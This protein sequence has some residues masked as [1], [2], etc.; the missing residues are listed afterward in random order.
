M[1]R[2]EAVCG[3]ALLVWAALASLAC[4]SE[5]PRVLDAPAG[6]L[7]A[8]AAVLE[9]LPYAIG[10][11][12]VLRVNVFAHPELSSGEWKQ[13][14]AGSPVDGSGAVMLPLL[15]AVPVAGATVAEVAEVL[16]QR[17]LRYLKE[18][19]VDVAVLEFG[20][21]RYVVYGAV[22]TPGVYALERPTTLLEALA[23][24]GGPDESANT[25][26]VAWVHGP[27]RAE[28][29]RLL[30]VSD[31]DPLVMSAIASG[32]LIFVGRRGWA[33]TAD[34]AR[35]VLPI[36]QAILLPLSVALQAATLTKL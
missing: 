12:D 35:D 11:G 18:P 31:L 22:H 36:L 19:H 28:N 24:A 16:E 23:R 2:S 7:A 4:R 10:S 15:G 14:S 8:N 32:D 13:G 5:P 30:D 6:A 34:A 33:H 25:R 9:P 20:S 27:L 21:Q 26:Q 1:N 17:L 29:M 3:R